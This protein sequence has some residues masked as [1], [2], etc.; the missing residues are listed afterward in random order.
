MSTTPNNP[1][2][3]IPYLPIEDLNSTNQGGAQFFSNVKQLQ[4][5]YGSSVFRVDR[6]GM[7]AGAEQFADAPWS[8]DWEGNMIANSVTLAG[9]LATGEALADIGT[10]NITSTYI[11]NGAIITDKLAANAVTAAK[12]SVTELSAITANVGTLTAGL[13]VGVEIRT[14]NTGDRIVLDNDRIRS[15][16]GNDTI[17]FEVDDG[18]VTIYDPVEVAAGY[19]FGSTGTNP[20]FV[21]SGDNAHSV[22]IETDEF[23]ELNPTSFVLLG[24]DIEMNGNDIFDADDIECVTL[25][26]TSDIRLKENIEPMKYGLKEVLKMNP[27]TYNF[28]EREE[29]DIGID[30]SSYENV[31]NRV[32]RKLSKRR[33]NTLLKKFKDKKQNKKNKILKRKK[34]LHL[35]FSAQDMYKIIPE[36]TENAQ[37]LKS[38]KKATIKKTQLIPILVQA[39]KE[40]NEKVEKLENNSEKS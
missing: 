10:G 22:Y 39:I 6:D 23:I 26:E 29:K 25:T 7:W 11:A 36:I 27:I 35:G 16:D 8:V 9:Y 31:L 13:I 24:S 32:N 4:V 2:D 18:F 21:I 28:K 38:N 3:N 12:I 19:I 1:Y 37:S 5:G 17:G 40:L 30:E 15:Y 20:R 34:N 14:S 33:K